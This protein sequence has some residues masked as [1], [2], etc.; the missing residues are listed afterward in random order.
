MLSG[1]SALSRNDVRP[2]QNNPEHKNC[3]KKNN[4]N[5]LMIYLHNSVLHS[6]AICIKQLGHKHIFLCVSHHIGEIL[7]F[8]SRAFS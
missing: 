3:K 2:P 1:S 8:H 4:N 5:C 7:V 6:S